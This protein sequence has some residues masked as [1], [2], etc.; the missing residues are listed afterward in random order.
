MEAGAHFDAGFD[1]AKLR[2]LQ[3]IDVVVERRV[4]VGFTNK[5]EVKVV[6]E[7]APA[8]GLVSV[9]VVA[10]EGGFEGSI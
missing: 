6:Q 1:D 10:Q 4:R 9:E 2:S 5:K 8:K 3:R 7:S